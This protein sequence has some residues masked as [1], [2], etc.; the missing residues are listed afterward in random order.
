MRSY[1]DDVGRLCDVCRQS[2]VFTSVAGLLGCLRLLVEDPEVRVLRIKNRLARCHSA[3]DTAGYRDVQVAPALD[4]S[5]G[6][7]R[8]SCTPRL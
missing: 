3:S 5:G 4:P 8:L 1:G 2:I 7:P 6:P